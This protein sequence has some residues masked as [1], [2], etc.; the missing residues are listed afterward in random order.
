MWNTL[1]FKRYFTT[2]KTTN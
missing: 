2:A 1:W